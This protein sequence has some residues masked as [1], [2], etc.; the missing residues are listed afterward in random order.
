MCSST[1]EDDVCAR[2]IRSSRTG[3]EQ[4]Y[5]S[6]LCQNMQMGRAVD[7]VPTPAISLGCPMRPEEVCVSMSDST[8][9][10]TGLWPVMQYLHYRLLRD[11]PEPTIRF[12]VMRAAAAAGKL[13][14]G[15]DT[16]IL[17]GLR[18]SSSQHSR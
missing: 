12:S 5:V 8:M 9:R 10:R 7:N 13:S 11:I 14:P 16:Q 3:E 6:H 15:N 2:N 18:G 17:L 4:C 1:V